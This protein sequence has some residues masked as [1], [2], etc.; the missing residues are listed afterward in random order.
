MTQAQQHPAHVLVADIG[1]TNARFA[2]ANPVTLELAEIRQVRCAEHPSLEAALGDYIGCL[3]NP[4]S[5]AA[6]AVAAPV[7]GGEVSLTNSSWSFAAA[8]LRRK[9]GLQ[10]ILILNDFEALAL[11]LPHLAKD[12][13]HQIGG[14]APVAKANKLALGP[15]TGLG[16]A[17]LVWSGKRWVAVPGEGGHVSLGG[18][19]ERQLALLERIRKGRDHLSAER[20]LSGPGLAE[21]YQAVAASRGLSTDAI[22]PNDV[23]VKGSSGEDEVAAE[24]LDLFAAWLGRFAGDAALLFGARGGVYLGGGIAPAIL[25]KLSAGVFRNAFEAKGRM[26]AYLAPVPVYVITAGFATLKGAAAALRDRPAT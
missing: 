26:S 13:L 15:G 20:V 11:S 3:R 18:E 6:I 23:L 2:L 17:G 19:D 7:T 4:P 10:Q 25:A 21:L 5:R 22:E 24:A 16:V 9:A 8:E 14:S 12:E 1:G